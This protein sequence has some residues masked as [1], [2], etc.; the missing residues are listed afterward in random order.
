MTERNKSNKNVREGARAGFVFLPGKVIR[1]F[2]V[3]ST[4]K[5]T[6]SFL[7]CWGGGGGGEYSQLACALVQ[8][9]PMYAWVKHEDT[10]SRKMVI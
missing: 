4:L 3:E 1:I 6:S 10:E 5:I 8:Q 2:L 7:F 9:N